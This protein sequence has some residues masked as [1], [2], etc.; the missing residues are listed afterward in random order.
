MDLQSLH[1]F[2]QVAEL[3]SFTRAGEKLGYSQPTVSFQIKQLEREMGVKLFD[4]I[5]HTVSLTDE[6]RDALAYAQ[7]I[8]RMSEEMV[9]GASKRYEARGVIRLA[10]PESMCSP[11]IAGGFSEFRKKYPNVSLSVTTADTSELFRL[12]DHNEVDIVC[13]LDNHIYNTSYVIMNEEKVDMHFVVSAKNPLATEKKV[14]IHDLLSQSFL[15]TEKSMSY[16]RMLDENLARRSIELHPILEI[17]NVD[18]ICKL[19]EKDVGISFLPDYL[20]LSND[21]IHLSAK[22]HI[23]DQRLLLTE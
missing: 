14:K 9:L 11:L 2:I 22:A 15:L 20:F 3:N 13:T 17:G 23:N 12:L 4:R 1:I 18:L 8:C 6:G 7:N 10:M 16:R 21:Y 5:G 19:V